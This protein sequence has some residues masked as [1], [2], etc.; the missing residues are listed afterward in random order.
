MYQFQIGTDRP[1]FSFQL[2]WKDFDGELIGVRNGL[3]Y[4]K[5]N[6][7]HMKNSTSYVAYSLATGKLVWSFDLPCLPLSP[8]M[9]TYPATSRPVLAP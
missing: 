3:C 6:S 8:I 7:Q 5:T 9:N 2:P 1:L 4:F